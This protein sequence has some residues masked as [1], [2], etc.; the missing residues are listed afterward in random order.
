M[1]GDENEIIADNVDNK[2]K[3]TNIDH[4]QHKS[5]ELNDDIESIPK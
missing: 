2:E 4:D 5:S 3:I 1:L